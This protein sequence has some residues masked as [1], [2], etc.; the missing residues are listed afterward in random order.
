MW[1]VGPASSVRR[2]DCERSDP[3]HCLAPGGQVDAKHL[4][5]ASFEVGLHQ[6]GLRLPR[7]RG[8]VRRGT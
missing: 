1:S 4:S 3:L 2:K 7:W 6:K 8:V 5:A